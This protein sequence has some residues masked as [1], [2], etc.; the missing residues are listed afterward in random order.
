MI[1]KENEIRG[2]SCENTEYPRRLRQIKNNP[3]VLYVKGRLPDERK[4]SV[5]IVGARKCS[6]YG[7]YM[8]KKLG[9]ALGRNGIN[10]ISGMAEGIDAAGHLGAMEGGGE[11]FAVLGCGADICYPKGNRRLYEEICEKGGVLSEYP[12]GTEP[13]NYYFP[14]R[15]R[16]ISG[17]AD[18]VVV[19]EARKKSGSLITVDL[20]LE[21]GREVYVLPG[22]VTDTLSYGCNRLIRDGAGI[23]L[24]VEDFLTE[25]GVLEKRGENLAENI[26]VSLAKEETLVYSCLGLEPK[27]IDDILEETGLEPSCAAGVL[28]QLQMKG[29]LRESFKNHYIKTE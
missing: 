26:K 4:K 11:T 3:K 13:K 12:K 27:S 28:I 14:M 15:N 10:V 20:A 1:Y 17:L 9:K 24:S 22:R 23:I 6:E 7:Y 18:I 2:I 29:L 21:Q 5:A 25:C 8:A 19:I 16:I